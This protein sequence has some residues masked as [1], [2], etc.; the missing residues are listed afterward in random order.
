MEKT[1]RKIS[2]TLL[3]FTA[4]ILEFFDGEP[5][6]ENVRPAFIVAITAWNA[7]ILDESKKATR[8]VEETR[9]LLKTGPELAL[10]DSM[11]ERKKSEYGSDRRLIGDFEVYKEAGEF[12]LRATA[13]APP[14]VPDT[15][16]QSEYFVNSIN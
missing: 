9:K 5:T 16:K 12:R 14:N 3:E 6:P 8:F 11:V 1:E 7:V 15:L 10:F 4:P 13:H 2:E